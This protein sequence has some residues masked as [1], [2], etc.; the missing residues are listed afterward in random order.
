MTL[1]SCLTVSFCPVDAVAIAIA[2]RSITALV[3]RMRHKE[4]LALR[5][6]DGADAK[7]NDETLRLVG[8]AVL[9]PLTVMLLGLPLACDGS[10]MSTVLGVVASVCAALSGERPST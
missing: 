4:A 7:R 1:F 8:L 10:T 6:S 2:T 9:R 3:R 5:G